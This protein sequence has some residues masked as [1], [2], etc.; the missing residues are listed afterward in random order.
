[1]EIVSTRDSAR[2]A[3]NADTRHNNSGTLKIKIYKPVT[4]SLYQVTSIM[5]FLIIYGGKIRSQQEYRKQQEKLVTA[6]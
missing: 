2:L 4:I 6:R 5:N 1:M 3:R